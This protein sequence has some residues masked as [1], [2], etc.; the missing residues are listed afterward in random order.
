MCRT[1]G[2]TGHPESVYQLASIVRVAIWYE[3]PDIFRAKIRKILEDNRS[4]M[5]CGGLVAVLGVRCGEQTRGRRPVLDAVEH[6]DRPGVILL[7]EMNAAQV[8]VVVIRR[9]RIELQRGVA[10]L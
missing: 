2:Q 5:R 1:S 7:D 6:L 3:T 9:Q 10:E 4:I 8:P